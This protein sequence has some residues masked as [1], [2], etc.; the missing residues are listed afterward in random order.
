VCRLNGMADL[1]NGRS[2]CKRQRSL[3][4]AT[5]SFISLC[6][7][8]WAN[9]NF[10]ALDNGQSRLWSTLAR[11][12]TLQ[13]ERSHYS[14]VECGQKM[15]HHATWEKKWEKKGTACSAKE[16]RI[17]DETWNIGDDDHDPRGILRRGPGHVFVVQGDLRK[18]S[19]DA[20]L[21]PTRRF[22]NEHWFPEGAPEGA[23]EIALEDFTEENRVLPVEGISEDQRRLWLGYVAKGQGVRPISW[24]L[25]A[26]SQ[27]L[28]EASNDLKQSGN[29]P[30]NSRYCH[31]L[32][33]PVIGSGV[34]NARYASGEL[35]AGLLTRLYMFAAKE[36]VDVVLVVRTPQMFSAAQATRWALEKRSYPAQ[37][38]LLSTRLIKS[39]K[40]LAALAKSG[41]LVYFIGAGASTAGG[42]PDWRSMLRILAISSGMKGEELMQISSLS[43]LDQAKVL[44]KRLAERK[45]AIEMSK[46][47]DKQREKSHNRGDP[48]PS[49]LQREV[50]RLLSTP[51]HSIIHSLLANIPFDAVVTTNYD[52]MF[53]DAVR[54]ATQSIYSIPYEVARKSTSKWILKLHGDVKHPED[55]VLTREQVDS[56]DDRRKALSGIVQ[57]LLITKHMLFV[58]F[59]LQDENFHKVATTMRR[60]INPEIRTDDPYLQYKSMRSFGTVL[61]LHDRP[62]LKDLWPDL[63]IIPIDDS[64]KRTSLVSAA[65]GLEIFL[66]RVSLEASTCSGHL[67]DTQFSGPSLSR[68]EW[69]LKLEVEKFMQALSENELA[70]K[71]S[72][73]E[74]VAEMI[75]KLGGD[76]D[77]IADT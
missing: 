7:I 23:Q 24:Y 77:S 32:A 72:G 70:K 2:R 38:S 49:A 27:F 19:A 41:E 22:S 43:F 51:Y 60:A 62:F 58:G 50:V 8:S 56:Y 55:I 4:A 35:L 46:H 10:G 42:L 53:E 39:A 57:A 44:E 63:S 21:Y 45:Y 34:G 9:R 25:K 59:S 48:N 47:W 66:D 76:P 6:L 67:L 20:V 64:G 16:D 29:P 17:F 71:A 14:R 65:R 18:I 30:K 15:L 28:I 54:G 26:A 73:C 36:C 3:I 13:C 61:S 75:R 37:W 69:A 52:T 68:E 74:A 31:L 11:S 33:L 1:G 5:G 40:R 12:R